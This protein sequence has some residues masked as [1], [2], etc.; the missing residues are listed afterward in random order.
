MPPLK[1]DPDRTEEEDRAW[2]QQ[3]Y[4]KA[5]ER[6]ERSAW[7]PFSRNLPMRGMALVNEVLRRAG[8]LFEGNAVLSQKDKKGAALP[9]GPNGEVRSF[10]VAG[11]PEA[12]QRREVIVRP[13]DSATINVTGTARA[14]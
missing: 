12:I 4:A 14:R 7:E 3:Q 1:R 8:A 6:A 11:G 13:G 9:R 5:R 2:Q 10:P